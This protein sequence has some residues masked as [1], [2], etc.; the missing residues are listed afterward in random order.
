MAKKDEAAEGVGRWC[1]GC[2]GLDENTALFRGYCAGCRGE[3]CDVCDDSGECPH[4]RGDRV[5]RK[6]CGSG[7]ANHRALGVLRCTAPRGHTGAHCAAVYEKGERVMYAWLAG[8]VPSPRYTSRQAEEGSLVEGAGAE[9]VD[10][11]LEGLL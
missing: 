11:L 4:C 6:R 9:R 8:G 2:D 1:D 5:T 7:S 3:G 10:D